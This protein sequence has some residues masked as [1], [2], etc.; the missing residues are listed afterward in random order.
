MKAKKVNKKAK[1]KKVNKT[2]KAKKKL[3]RYCRSGRVLW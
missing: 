1:A 3:S 2:T